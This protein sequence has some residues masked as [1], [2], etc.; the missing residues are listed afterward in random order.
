MGIFDWDNYKNGPSG[1]SL[2]GLAALTPIAWGPALWNWATG[3][4]GWSGAVKGSAA[5]GAAALG[6]GAAMGG[7][8][9]GGAAAAGSGAA[10]GSAGAAGGGM[11][12]MSWIAPLVGSGMSMYGQTQA[13]AANERIADKQMTFQANMS[14]TAHQREVADLYAAGLN[15]ILSANAG[16]STPTGASAVMENTLASAATGAKDAVAMKM[17]SAMQG[18]EMARIAKGMELTDSQIKNTEADTRKKDTERRTMTK[19]A[20][21]GDITQGLWDWAVKKNA[22]RE[23]SN[24]KPSEAAKDAARKLQEKYGGDQ[25]T[26]VLQR[27][28]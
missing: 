3:E 15:P 2:G 9:G 28:H 20:I 10:A 19:D 21:T 4:D 12:S 17:Q 8:A 13:N 11:S 23:Q 27:Q 6:G 16:A 26:K 7:F 14:N 25:W 24:W 22:E 5:L 18:A 1:D